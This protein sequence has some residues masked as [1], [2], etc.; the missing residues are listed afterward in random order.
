MIMLASKRKSLIGIN[1][2]SFIF[3]DSFTWSIQNLACLI[4]I[5]EKAKNR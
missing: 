1:I 5:R 4:C 3:M 2:N